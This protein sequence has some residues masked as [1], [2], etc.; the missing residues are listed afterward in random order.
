[1]GTVLTANFNREFVPPTEPTEPTE[2]TPK[3]TPDWNE[4]L[5]S[6]TD[7]NN[8]FAPMGMQIVYNGKR[9]ICIMDHIMESAWNPETD[10]IRW[11][12]AE[13]DDEVVIYIPWSN[14]IVLK[15]GQIVSHIDGRVYKVLKDHTSTA[16]YEPGSWA[17]NNEQYF[18]LIR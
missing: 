2:P 6:F 8:K 5:P 4:L 16:S 13:E 12:L 3:P 9:Y 15:T 7:S 1:M 14:G 17:A 11:K 18:E 10:T